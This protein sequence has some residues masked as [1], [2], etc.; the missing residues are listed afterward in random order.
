MLKHF[1]LI[2]LTKLSLIPVITFLLGYTSRSFIA[3]NYDVFY[4]HSSLLIILIFVLLFFNK[5]I[6][7][8]YPTK[9]FEVICIAIMSCFTLGIALVT[10]QENLLFTRWLDLGL[11]PSND[12]EDYV[13]QSSQYLLENNLYS[14]KGRIIF[15]ILYAGLLA[16]FNLNVRTV[17]LIITFF[18]GI[19]TFFTSYTIYHKY[20]FF[21]SIIFSGL[22][23][24]F[25]IEHVGG[26]STENFGY[27]LGGIAFIFYF[28]FIHL[29]NTKLLN[30]SVF[31]V[32]ILLGYLIRPS[33]PFI[34]PFLFIW[35]LIYLRNYSKI[36]IYRIISIA[37]FSLFLILFAS[38]LLHENKSPDTAQE[39]GNIYDSWYA[40]HE[41]GKYYLNGEYDEIPGTLWTKLAEDYPNIVE[42]KGK[43]FVKAKRDIIISTLFLSPKNY[44]V[45]SLLQ[46]KNFFNKS[47]NYTEK[48]DHSAGF[49][50]IEFYHYRIIL[51]L[52][53]SLGGLISFIYFYKYKKIFH[54]LII[55]IFL[56]TLL[57][58]PLI[59]GGEAR[60]IS[61]VIFFI[62]LV[63]IFAINKIKKK[64]TNCTE[65]INLESMNEINTLSYLSIIPFFFLFLIFIKAL[66]NNYTYLKK[67]SFDTNLT[68]REGK[69]LKSIIFNSKSGFFVNTFQK[70]T[71]KKHKDFS[72]ILDVYAD[73]SVI[74]E[75]YE[76]DDTFLMT[77][78]EINKRDSFK[79]LESFI[80]IHNGRIFEMSK[81][82]KTIYN[83]LTAQFLTSE[84][85]Y[86]KPINFNNKTLDDIILLEEDIVKEGIN[87]L[88]VCV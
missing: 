41:L 60:T 44:I 59:L 82:E 55:L 75:K 49:L 32:F 48:F 12:A 66:D 27:I 16:E 8:R 21:C 38:K 4:L 43:E 68:C 31:F 9:Q 1:N 80:K 87:T 77:R 86:V 53:F 61:T 74:L 5:L 2:Q 6:V 28:K 7:L 33:I 30:F 56:A 36:D 46:I 10:I 22:C 57:S 13:Q 81:N 40:T 63:I 26:A 23:T 51:L 70:E 35:A 71:K 20:G 29:K 42:L 69:T 24:D 54:L 62:N 19:V 39:F 34:L 73:K 84:A 47:K 14:S 50:F 15:P 85:F 11:F 78:E 3:W 88:A 25:L 45:G 17:Q 18:T 37:C 72:E 76:Y 83:K 67:Q 79:V 64:F 52:L 65:K 58:Q